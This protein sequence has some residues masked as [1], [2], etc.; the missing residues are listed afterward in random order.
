MEKKRILIIEDDVNLAGLLSEKLNS[1]GFETEIAP[2]GEK[3][4]EAT[5]RQPDLILLDI[6]LPKLSGLDVMKAIREKSN[7]G[8]AVPIV[9]TSNLNPDDDQII[10]SI[11]NYN[12]VFYLVKAEYSL[13]DIIQ[14][15]RDILSPKS[16]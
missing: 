8:M 12:P 14:K 9:I 2:D 7:W 4:L 11:A 5:E 6:M 13:D 15:V 16:I 1:S 3:G 10:N